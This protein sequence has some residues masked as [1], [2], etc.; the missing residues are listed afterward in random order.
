[1]KE[2]L[3]TNKRAY[4]KLAKEYK[5]RLKS[6]K[7][8]EPIILA[9]FI[10][11][12]KENFKGVRVLELG[13]GSGLASSFLNKAGF[14][15]T[16]IDISKNIIKVAR[17]VSP[18]T[19]FI[20]ADFLTY[21]FSDLKFEGIFAKAFIHLFPKEDAIKVLKKIKDLLIKNG[22]VYIATTLHERSKEGFFEKEDYNKRVKRFRRK[23]EESDLIIT[24]REVGFEI[25]KKRY[26]EEKEKSKKWIDFFLRAI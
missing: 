14:E 4:D 21:D 24:I 25:I 15:T 23:W 12:L 19:N 3:K 17:E 1:M 18:K 26:Y 11:Y 22:V 10:K 20:H 2:Y 16:A 5:E 8:S 13:P 6:Y 9:P 7:T